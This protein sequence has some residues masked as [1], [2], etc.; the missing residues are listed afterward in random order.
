[1]SEGARRRQ[2]LAA[3]RLYLVCDASFERIEDAVAGGVD[4]VQ[5]RERALDDGQLLTA[6]RRMRERTHAAGALFLVNDRPDIAL[7]AGADGVHVGQD[8]LLPA[9][10]RRLVGGELLVGLSTHAPAEIEAAADVDYIG[11]GPV[12]ETPT[13]PGRPAVGVELVRHA[14]AHAAVPWFAIGGVDPESAAAVVAA[15]AS[16][17]AVVRAITTA[18]DPRAVAAALCARLPDRLASSA[19]ESSAELVLDLRLELGEGPVWNGRAGELVFVD[20]MA[21]GLHLFRPSDGRHVRAEVGQPIGAVGLRERA[22]LVL[23][24]RDGFALIDTGD[25]APRLVASLHSEGQGMR[26]NDG[27]C[28]ARGGFLAGS[29]HVDARPGAGV[30]HR[31]DPGG[32]VTPLL[33]GLTISNGMDWSLDG[34]TLYLVDGPTRV[35]ACDWDAEA[36]TILGTRELLRFGPGEGEPDGLTVDA[37]GGIWLCIWDGGEVRRYLP[38]GTLERRLSLPAARVTSC[39][40]GGD[41]LT[42][43]YVT[44]ARTGLSDEQL[45]AQPLAGGLF[46]LRP[47]VRGRPAH[48]FAG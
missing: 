41:D 30:L 32:G 29:M 15:G 27:A 20:I 48:R 37:E 7:L 38:D 23:A 4:I 39:C 47:G 17:L 33:D 10:V 31:L 36:G 13:K 46:R 14:A 43:L 45:A 25:G 3:S 5:L 19:V 44:T 16:R 26:L 8:D 6:A 24:L 35:L 18:A 12:H 22:G 11:V 40:F 28:D 2:R 9:D 34:R 42:E 21:G 1:V